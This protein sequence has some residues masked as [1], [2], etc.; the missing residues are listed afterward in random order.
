MCVC[1]CVRVSGYVEI[2]ILFKYDITCMYMI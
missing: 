2:F 1:V